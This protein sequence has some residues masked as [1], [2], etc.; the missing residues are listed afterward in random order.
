M[1][2]TDG[3]AVEA[4]PIRSH[5]AHRIRHHDPNFFTRRDYDLYPIRAARPATGQ[6]AVVVAC[7]T[8]GEAVRLIVNSDAV[9]RSSRT[10]LYVALLGGLAVMIGGLVTLGYTTNVWVAVHIGGM[11]G[12]PMLVAAVSIFLV[13]RHDA[14]EGVKIES[15]T[16]TLRNP[17]AFWDPPPTADYGP[18]EVGI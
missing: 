16:H 2:K 12:L 9:C 17:G 4:F 7:G 10:T 5:L 15:S 11:L 8:C 18:G 13:A 1:P 6:T 14:L 3:G